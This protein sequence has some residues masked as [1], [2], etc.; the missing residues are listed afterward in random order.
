MQHPLLAP[1]NDWNSLVCGPSSF[2]PICV[3][4]CVIDSGCTSLLVPWPEDPE[5]TLRPLLRDPML[6]CVTTLSG[7]VG[8]DHANFQVSAP[9]ARFKVL[10]DGA[11]FGVHVSELRFVITESARRWLVEQDPNLC[12]GITERHVHNMN[13]D[14]ALVGQ[15]VL[16]QLLCVQVFDKG[17]LILCSA[18]QPNFELKDIDHLTQLAS[19][20]YRQEIG[21]AHYAAL[22]DLRDR[23]K[24]AQRDFFT[25]GRRID[26]FGPSFRR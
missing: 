10:L 21:S 5:T 16:A 12:Q 24:T 15:T 6:K 25:L 14:Y 4:R 9:S 7:S 1:L 19:D 2:G 26:R 8:S 17:L 11:D 22:R 13:L 3:Q 23:Q 18:T 20:M